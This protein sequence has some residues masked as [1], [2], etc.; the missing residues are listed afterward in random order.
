MSRGDLVIVAALRDYAKPRPAVI[1]RSNAIV[2]C[3]ITAE[4]VEADFRIAIEPWP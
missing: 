4:L 3:Q 2:I 1:V